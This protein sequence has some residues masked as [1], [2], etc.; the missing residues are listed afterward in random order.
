MSHLRVFA[1]NHHFQ[2]I[3]G[4]I[5]TTI[6]NFSE[7]S[8]NEWNLCQM[9]HAHSMDLYMEVFESFWLLISLV[10][11]YLTYVKITKASENFL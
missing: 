11:T 1:R 4:D 2:A 9:E 10:F 6:L 8:I 3:H 7:K 5:F